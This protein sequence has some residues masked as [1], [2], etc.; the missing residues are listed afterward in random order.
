V[1]AGKAIDLGRQAVMLTLIVGLPV[2]LTGFVVALVVSVLQ[3]A[4]QVQDQTLSFVPRIVAMLLAVVVAGP[5]MLTR[6]VDFARQMFG[7]LP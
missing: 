4:T 1:D 7:Q 6:I 3:A 2:L 5:W